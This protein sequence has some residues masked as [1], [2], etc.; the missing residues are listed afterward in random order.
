MRIEHL[1][2][3]GLSPAEARREAERQFGDIEGTRRYC[4]RQDLEKENRVQRLLFVQDLAQDARI[5][6]RNLLRVPAL[7]LTV[8]VTVGLGIGA[9]T[10]IFAAV[11]AALLQPLPYKDPGQLVRIYT[12]APPNRFSLSVVDY[13]ALEAQQSQFELIAGYRGRAMGFSNGTVAERLTGREVTW[14][15]FGLL[16]ITPTLG[17]DFTEQDG[18]PGSPR[19]VVI[20][21]GLWQRRL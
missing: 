4:R 20:S 17:R 1:R 3:N 14:T 12:D 8:V 2:T 21:D 6:L 18:R 11:N 16:G 9:T 10:A 15:Y 19:V 5:G 13:R 7:A